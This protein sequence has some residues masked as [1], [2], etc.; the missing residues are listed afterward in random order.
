MSE[1][2]G[3]KHKCIGIVV[4]PSSY[5]IVGGRS[6]HNIPL[7]LL[8]EDVL[9]ADLGQAKRGDLLLGG[10]SGESAALRISMPEALYFYTRDDWADWNSHDEIYRACWTMNDAYIFGEGYAKLGWTPAKLIEDWLAE[11]ILAFVLHEYPERWGM[12]RGPV[13]LQQDGSI[14]RLPTAEEVEIW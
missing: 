1:I 14:C 6:H 13:A 3:Y 4:C 7:Y 5:A 2:D 8:E 9:D 10:G 11:H 12:L